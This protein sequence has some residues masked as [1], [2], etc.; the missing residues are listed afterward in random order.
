MCKIICAY[1][2][3]SSVYRREEGQLLFGICVAVGLAGLVLGIETG[4]MIGRRK[5]K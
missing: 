5:R 3:Y 2:E 4:F 1:G